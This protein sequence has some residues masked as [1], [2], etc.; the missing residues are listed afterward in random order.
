MSWNGSDSKK[1][2][3]ANSGT[4][5]GRLK[6]SRSPRTGRGLA[7]GLIVILGAGLAAWLMLGRSKAPVSTKVTPVKPTRIKAVN[8]ATNKVQTALVAEPEPRVYPEKWD[9]SFVTNHELRLHFS[10]TIEVRTNMSGM[11]TQRYVL[12]NGQTWRMVKDPPP[13]FENPCD[14]AIAMVLSTGAGAPIP[15]VPGLDDVNLDAEFAKSMASPIEIFD[16]DSPGRVAMKLAVK[17][18][19]SEIVK[20]IKDGDKRSVGEILQEYITSNNHALD[21]QGDAL[22]A[23]ERIREE[24]GDEQANQYLEKVN[25]KLAAYGIEPIASTVNGRQKEPA[26]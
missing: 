25:E 14:N 4:P 19:K 18:A 13:P 1:T 7:A 23:V 8:P 17:N 2:A 22:R 16:T 12:P 21:M 3:V 5:V 26:K 20:M 11:V 10:K 6:P 15:P 9:D 24:S